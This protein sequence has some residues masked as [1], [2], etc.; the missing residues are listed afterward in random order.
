[1]SAKKE[2]RYYPH[3]ALSFVLVSVKCKR[4]KPLLCEVNVRL[5]A[6][7]LFYSCYISFFLHIF[8]KL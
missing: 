8:T 2:T 4:T 1:M 5:L 3:S 7:F 6:F